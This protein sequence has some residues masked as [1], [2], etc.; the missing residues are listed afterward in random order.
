MTLVPPNTARGG[1]PLGLAG[2]TAETRYVG[3]TASGAPV[4]GTF[5]KGDFVV[6]QDGSLY[7]CTAAGSPGTWAQVSGGGGAFV[8]QETVVVGAGGAPTIDFQSIPAT[9]EDLLITLLARGEAAANSVTVNMRFNNDSGANYTGERLDA[10]SGTVGAA[11]EGA[12]DTQMR[13]GEITADNIGTAHGGNI[14]TF[15]PSYAS[16]AFFKGWYSDGGWAIGDA[17]TNQNSRTMHGTWL[18]AA[19]ISRVTL[20][21]ASGD[22]K[23]GSRASLYLLG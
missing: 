13:I 16:T 9:S 12:P 17:S 1:Y 23:V 14:Q 22:F 6:T 4:S 7:I 5:A 19:A 21:P 11:G 8:L 15:V 18:S 3:A 20:I 10:S 2:A